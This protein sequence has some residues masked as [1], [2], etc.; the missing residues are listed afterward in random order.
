[1]TLGWDIHDP[2]CLGTSRRFPDIKRPSQV[3]S[4]LERIITEHVDFRVF[5]G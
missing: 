4:Q 3:L 2:A 1:M 5:T